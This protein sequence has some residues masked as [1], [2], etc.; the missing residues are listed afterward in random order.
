M[1]W[2]PIAYVIPFSLFAH[3][4]RDVEANAEDRKSTKGWYK[5]QYAMRYVLVVDIRYL[6][7]VIYLG[8]RF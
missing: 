7:S 1:G 6:L 2:L 5:Q 4:S 8:L 3:I